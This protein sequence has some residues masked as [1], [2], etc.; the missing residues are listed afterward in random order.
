VRR[1][2]CIVTETFPPEINGVAITL[3]RLADGL[4]A[5]GYRVSV[6]RPRRGAVDV[7]GQ[8]ND[9]SLL[10]AG[11]PL[12]GYR[13]L[14]VGIPAHRALRDQWRRRSPDAIYVATEGPLG[15]SAVRAARRLQIPVFSGFHTNFHSYSRHYHAGWLDPWIRR[16]LGWFH[17]H[18]DATIAASAHLADQ[19]RAIGIANVEVL[20]RGVDSRLFHPARRSA[21]LR[22]QWGAG[23]DDLIALY[24]G[25][26]AAEKNLALAIRAFR[27]MERAGYARRMVLVGD[28]PLRAE[29]EENHRDLIFLGVRQGEEL[30]RCYA[31]ADVFLFPSETETFGNVTLEALASGLVVIAYDYAAARL[32]I[33]DGVSGVLAPFGDSAAFIAAALRI[34]RERRALPLMRRVAREHAAALDWDRVVRRFASLLGITDAGAPAAEQD[35]SAPIEPALGAI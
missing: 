29:L 5:Q 7:T 28:G 1:H 18:T 4:R 11:L 30:A 31:S 33:R 27:E 2:V 19:L 15:W 3:A 6:V 34:G 12:P 14:R 16:Y 22:R 24:V 10:V 9:D 21:E 25:R 13:G 35:F 20:G 32:H 23:P 8:R 17:N 26:L